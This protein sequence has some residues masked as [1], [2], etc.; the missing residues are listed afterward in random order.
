MK[1]T[2]AVIQ[3]GKCK[4]RSFKLRFVVFDQVQSIIAECP[5]GRVV[6]YRDFKQSICLN[7]EVSQ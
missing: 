1:Q 7:P 2:D 4:S 5:C 3:C 6:E